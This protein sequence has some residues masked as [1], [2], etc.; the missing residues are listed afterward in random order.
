MKTAYVMMG[1]LVALPA[2]FSACSSTSP[3]PAEVRDKSLR[4]LISPH[5][6]RL[7]PVIPAASP[8]QARGQTGRSDCAGQ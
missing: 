5:G 4:C 1:V 6:G 7:H 8:I 2:L 3:F